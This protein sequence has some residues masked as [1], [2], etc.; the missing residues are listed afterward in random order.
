[1]QRLIWRIDFWVVTLV[2]RGGEVSLLVEILHLRWLRFRM[3]EEQPLFPY[4]SLFLLLNT[5]N[6]PIS[7]YFS[8]TSCLTSCVSLLT[9][10]S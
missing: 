8:K 5:S 6:S 9:S 4:L 10:Y 1:M 3:T 7:F 2:R